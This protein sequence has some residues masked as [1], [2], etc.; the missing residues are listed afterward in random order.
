MPFL[1]TRS[2]AVALMVALLFSL[3]G[4][5]V[6]A[7]NFEWVKSAGGT[8]ETATYPGQVFVDKSG[9]TY[10]TGTFHKKTTFDNK[11]DL[12]ASTV[13]EYGE[14]FIVKYAPD[15]KMLWAIRD[16]GTGTEYAQNIAVDANGDIYISGFFSKI[17]P[18]YTCEI[19]GVVLDVEN[20]EHEYFLAKYDATGKFKWVRQTHNSGHT[21][22]SASQMV[23]DR[24]DNVI[25]QGTF[26]GEIT[27]GDKTLKN[28]GKAF[29]LFTAK[30]DADGNALWANS[31]LSHV[32][33]VQSTDQVPGDM[34]MATGLVANSSGEIYYTG[35]FKGKLD[36]PEGP[37]KSQ[38]GDIFF[39]KLDANGQVIWLK[40]IGNGFNN[41]VSDLELD[42]KENPYLLLITT[43]PTFGSVS[44][45]KGW[46][47]FV[48]K[49][50]QDGN[51]YQ[52]NSLIENAYCTAMAIGHED[53]VYAIGHYNPQARIDCFLLN[54]TSSNNDAFFLSQDASGSLQW[55]KEI[56]GLF[57]IMTMDIRLDATAENAY[58]L[59]YFRGD[60]SFD[61][62]KVLN[63]GG[64]NAGD[65]GLFTDDMFIAKVNNIGVY[66]PPPPM[67][68]SCDIPQ[69]AKVANT[70]TLKA[71]VGS[72]ASSVTYRWELGNGDVKTTQTPT[73]SYAYSTPGTYPIIVSA[74][75]GLGCTLVCG[76]AIVVSE[77]NPEMVIPNIFTPNGDGK[78]DV[79]IVQNYFEDQPFQIQIFNRWGKQVASI[80]DGRN[81]WD[82]AGCSEGL[83]FYSI[84]IAGQERKGWVELVR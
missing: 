23:L 6:F 18:D 1:T 65:S 74:T 53:K 25:M 12:V 22:N 70:I 31:Q 60:I 75:D 10:V 35:V 30:F 4:H 69:E 51:A 42:S 48:A 55:V 84:R 50:D 66:E 26:K 44:N 62:I 47:S 58:G 49:F 33:Y 9:H 34:I 21:I 17:F 24:Q 56:K 83:Y 82:G 28:D 71:N 2:V 19:G 77:P 54:S 37:A 59:G 80:P 8:R 46:G 45:A 32:D 40:L 13:T 38:D 27:I 52:I 41:F 16:G 61:N 3:F 78:N 29:S 36:F 57:G 7:Q 81:G 72:A 14:I 63:I 15:G 79:F 20:N 43:K 67:S 73:L 11:V 68:L 64:A 76:T 39:V 5:S